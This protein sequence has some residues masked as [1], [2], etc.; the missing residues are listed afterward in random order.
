MVPMRCKISPPQPMKQ[1]SVDLA[2]DSPPLTCN[3]RTGPLSLT[4]VFH[5]ALLLLL[6][7]RI[8][9]DI[10]VRYQYSVKYIHYKYFPLEASV[11]AQ[12]LGKTVATR[13]EKLQAHSSD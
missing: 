5:R 10:A 1:Q 3:L 2:I 6:K 9:I 8:W 11:Q 4:R 12:D 7:S 13:T